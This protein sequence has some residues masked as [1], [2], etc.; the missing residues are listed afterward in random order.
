[1]VVLEEVAHSFNRAQQVPYAL[2]LELS[3]VLERQD[4][5]E[6]RG[7][8]CFDQL[9]QDGVVHLTVDVHLCSSALW[10]LST[11]GQLGCCVVEIRNNLLHSVL[12]LQ[13]GVGVGRVRK[14]VGLVQQTSKDTAL[15]RDEG[16]QGDGTCSREAMGTVGTIHPL[17]V[18]LDRF[19][20]RAQVHVVV[21]Q[22]DEVCGGPFDRRGLRDRDARADKVQGFSQLFRKTAQDATERWHC[23]SGVST[24]QKGKAH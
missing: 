24:T 21:G 11:H 8:R 19:E 14:T 20:L 16:L 22:L 10:G 1:M 13:V 18:R 5:A 2:R 6:D 9:A 23:W 3:D 15:A 4:A 17:N 12:D 7:N